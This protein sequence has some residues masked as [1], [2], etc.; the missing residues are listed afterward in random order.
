MFLLDIYGVLKNE[1]SQTSDILLY[2][3]IA[4]FSP[5]IKKSF[6]KR[7]FL[8]SDLNVKDKFMSTVHEIYLGI[9]LK[10]SYSAIC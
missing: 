5:L 4:I 9:Q 6:K 1:V 10:C 7:F 2:F 3:L 8:M